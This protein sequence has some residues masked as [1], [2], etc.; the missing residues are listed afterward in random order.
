[1]KDLLAFRR[2]ITPK[3]IKIIFWIGVVLSVIYGLATLI[4]DGN[5][6]GL[7]MIIIGPFVVRIVCELFIL[8]FQIN[9]TLTDIKNAS[10]NK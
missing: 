1:M 9:E 2:M 4:G 3:I 10:E 7:L 5:L 6:L 8:P